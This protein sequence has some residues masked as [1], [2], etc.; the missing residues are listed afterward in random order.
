MGLNCS[1]IIIYK[2]NNRLEKLHIYNIYIY[3]FEFYVY[4]LYI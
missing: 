3:I 4:K 1:Y 2:G